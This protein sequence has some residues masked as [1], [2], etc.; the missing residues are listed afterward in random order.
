MWKGLK[1]QTHVPHVSQTAVKGE[2]N[3]TMSGLI[4]HTHIVFYCYVINFAYPYS[5]DIH[6][7]LKLNSDAVM[8]LY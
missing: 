5:K 4:D 2:S 6:D 7:S 3:Y 1:R 8:Y